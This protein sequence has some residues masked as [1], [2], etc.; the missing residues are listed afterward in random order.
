M[1]QSLRTIGTTLPAEDIIHAVP[2]G[3]DP[4]TYHWLYVKGGYLIK[5]NIKSGELVA[6]VKL[7][8]T[9]EIVAKA[10]DP[11]QKITTTVS[12]MPI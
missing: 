1:S 4:S 9:K 6:S 3:L 8:S 10:G 7:P 2:D 5:I 12:E 11:Q